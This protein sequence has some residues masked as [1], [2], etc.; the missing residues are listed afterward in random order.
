MIAT[1]KGK[2]A[3]K[4]PGQVV[5][6]VGGVGYGVVIPLSTY[7]KLP[8]QG[9]AVRLLIHT[10]VREDAFLLFGFGTAEERDVFLLLTN[11]PGIGPKL[12]VNVLSGIPAPDLREAV[13]RQDL[14][15]IRSVPGV[16]KKTA[17]KILLELRDKIGALEEGSP[18]L[19]T[20]G[21]TMYVDLISALTNMGYPRAGA[22][23]G[24]E[25]AFDEA[26]EDADFETLFKI[27][28]KN[29]LK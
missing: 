8:P 23:N 18:S 21:R 2:L 12:A 22:E 17:E 10:H 5:V 11:V 16:G 29:L 9:E 26:G 24:V 14:A 25:K 19:G 7:T 3:E 20:G 28:L 27:A 13:S 1:L 15:R 6:D 4:N